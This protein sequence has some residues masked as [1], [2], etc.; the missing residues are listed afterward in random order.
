MNYNELKKALER[1]GNKVVTSKVNES[2]YYVTI[3]DGETCI[4][5]LHIEDGEIRMLHPLFLEYENCSNR[6]VH[7]ER[8]EDWRALALY[9]ALENV[10]KKVDVEDLKL[11]VD[12]FLH[13]GCHIHPQII[14]EETPTVEKNGFGVGFDALKLDTQD[15]KPKWQQKV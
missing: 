13:K 11:I 14:R 10:R 12:I 6:Y 15:L 9:Y 3:F 5:E 2:N 1:Q 4:Y 7:F 8:H